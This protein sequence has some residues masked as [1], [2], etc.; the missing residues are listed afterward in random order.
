MT[1]S[2]QINI[3]LIYFKIFH[4]TDF[5]C[6]KTNRGSIVSVARKTVSTQQDEGIKLFMMHDKKKLNNITNGIY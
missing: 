5:K 1:N 6:T 4:P 3:F 2:L